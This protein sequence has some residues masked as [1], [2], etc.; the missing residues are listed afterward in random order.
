MNTISTLVVKNNNAKDFTQGFTLLESLLALSVCSLFLLLPTLAIN[1][2][3]QVLQVEQFFN[4]VEKNILFTQ[5][6][7][8]VQSVDTKILF[9]EEK[10]LIEFVTQEEKNGQLEIPEAIMGRG[11]G[12]VTFK[13]ITGNNGVLGKYEFDWPEKRQRVV[14]QFQLGSGK[15]VKKILSL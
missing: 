11:P 5:Q 14:F 13:K 15:Y 9:S 3:Q 4:S 7:A 12:K 8:V 1:E 6:M 10:Q 2:W